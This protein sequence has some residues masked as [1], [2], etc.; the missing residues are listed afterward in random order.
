MAVQTHPIDR[1]NGF[2]PHFHRGFEHIRDVR[3][4]ATNI[5][6][7]ATTLYT[8]PSGKKAIVTAAAI[9]SLNAVG[10]VA[11]VGYF[12]PSGQVA[13]A[14]YIHI[15]TT[16]ATTGVQGAG[17]ALNNVG[18]LLNPG[19]MIQATGAASINAAYTVYEVPVSAPIV[20]VSGTLPTAGTVVTLYT[21]PNGMR[22]DQPHD[23]FVGNGGT[24]YNQSTTTTAD[25]R[26]HYTVNGV[27]VLLSRNNLAAISTT[28]W[29]PFPFMVSSN[30][31][32]ATTAAVS[33]ALGAGNASPV[34]YWGIFH[35]VW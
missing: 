11:Y 29:V 24:F 22:A 20:G 25:I 7:T 13:G 12:V 17:A 33:F 1:L 14:S 2:S 26:G 21:C 5:P 23:Y 27:N 19:D 16:L 9:Y 28:L 15:N 35:E 3:V 31:V 32:G 18:A 10:P 8:C 6:S 30:P 34:N 4:S